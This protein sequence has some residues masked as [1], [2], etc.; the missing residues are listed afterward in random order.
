MPGR[1]G[2]SKRLSVPVTGR[3]AGGD[4][5]RVQP[6]LDRV[7]VELASAT[8]A[9]SGSPSATAS[10]SAT[11][12]SPV[13]ISVTGC[14]TCSRVFTSRKKN[15]AGRGPGRTR[16]CRHRR[17]RSPCRRRRLRC[18][19]RRV[20]PRPRRARGLLDHLLVRRWIEHSR[21]N[22]WT[23]WPWESPKICTSMWRGSSTKRSRRRFRSPKAA[24]ASRWA[25]ALRRAG[26]RGRTTRMP[27]PPPPIGRLDQQRKTDLFG[28]LSRE[29]SPSAPLSDL[30]RRAE[31]GR[32]HRHQLLGRCLGA[33]RVDGCGGG[34]TK[35]SPAAAQACAKS[36]FSERKP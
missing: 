15:V 18:P 34:P 6:G 20:A 2:I 12:S 22:R 36:A 30:K 7:A 23:T 9:G 33:H 16:P 5:L 26:R 11:R 17:S 24:W 1:A 32:P 13:T 14:S 19:A 35:V 31:P 3:N 8:C 29:A 21:S 28:R 10:W 4:V 27:R 25:P